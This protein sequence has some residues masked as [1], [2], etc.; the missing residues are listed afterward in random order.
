MVVTTRREARFTV[1]DLE[2]MPYVEGARYELVDGELYVSTAPHYTHQF[3]CSRLITALNDWSRLATAGEAV[4]GPG[5]VFDRANA[6]IPDVIWV[7]H[8]RMTHVLGA[9]GK[10]HQ[11]PDLVI[12]VLSPGTINTARDREIKLGLYSRRRVPEY[13][14]VD[15]QERQ[16]EVYRHAGESL[17]LIVTLSES[18][19]LSSPLLPG[20]SLP[21][22]ELFAP[23][24]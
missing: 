15:W 5:L 7:R 6:V 14:I 9:D 23:L 22:A 2:Q 3:T 17:A 13:W 18:G 11:A 24:S 19:A 16:V 8:S 12:E 4:G 1:D 10:L 20:F 21:L